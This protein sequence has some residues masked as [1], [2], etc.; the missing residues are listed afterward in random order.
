[1]ATSGERIAKLE[2]RVEAVEG[3]MEA[4]T[5]RT[6]PELRRTLETQAE[7]L[8]KIRA[9]TERQ[10]LDF[11]WMM[12]ILTFILLIVVAIGEGVIVVKLTERP[13]AGAVTAAPVK[14]P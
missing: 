3:T 2:V 6:M 1:M 13:A 8:R 4:M 5:T 12:R 10:G 9:K 11:G 7:E 14:H